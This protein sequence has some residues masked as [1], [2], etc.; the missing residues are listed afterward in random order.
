M[1]RARPA[2]NLGENDER[3]LIE[4]AKRDPRRFAE[5]YEHNFERVYSYV[6]GR[7]R[8]RS[9]AQDVTADVFHQ[10]LANIE[11]FEWRGVPFAA[12]L[13]RIAANAIVDRAQRAAREE[14]SHQD[15]PDEIEVEEVEQRALVLRLVG[16]FPEDQSKVVGVRFVEEHCD[17]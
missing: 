4:S 10:A 5:L 12:W 17:I 15:A 11:K 7:L 13:Y 2:A 14:S 16:N 3:L 8:D 1:A 6:V 9:E